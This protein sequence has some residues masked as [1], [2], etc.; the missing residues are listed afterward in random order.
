MITTGELK[1][2]RRKFHKGDW[3]WVYAHVNNL[4]SDDRRMENLVHIKTKIIDIYPY[5][6][7]TGR[8]WFSWVQLYQWNVLEQAPAKGRK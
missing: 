2:Y 4:F 8:G 5:G 3:I 7:V 6:C 1:H